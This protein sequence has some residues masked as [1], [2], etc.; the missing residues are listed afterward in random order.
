VEEQQCKT[1]KSIERSL[2]ILFPPSLP[3]SPSFAPSRDDD[4][5]APLSL[6]ALPLSFDHKPE[7]ESEKQRVEAA[8]GLVK[9]TNIA[10]DK[11]SAPVLI[12]R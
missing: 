5:C 2:I 4:D 3:P 12:W 10:P 6:H 8:G 9:G 7:L 1:G 11:D